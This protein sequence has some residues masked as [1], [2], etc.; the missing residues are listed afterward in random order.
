MKLQGYS[1]HQPVQVLNRVSFKQHAELGSS[2]SAE[3]NS[4]Q[5]PLLVLLSTG[6][7]S[8]LKSL[9]AAQGWQ[10]RE[11]TYPPPHSKAIVVRV[12][13]NVGNQLIRGASQLDPLLPV[14]VCG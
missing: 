6:G 10:W 3:M 11:Q 9:Q 4:F 8:F 2:E 1:A 14:L 12:V 5:F 7:S 13:L